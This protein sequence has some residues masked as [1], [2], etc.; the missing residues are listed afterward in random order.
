MLTA[1]THV[2]TDRASRYLAQ[3]C[4]HAKRMGRHTNGGADGPPEVRQIE[5]SG[6]DGVIG[7][8]TGRCVLHADAGTL[9]VRAEADDEAGL[10]RIRDG[11]SRRLET[12][13]RRDGLRVTWPDSEAAAATAPPRRR[14]RGRLPLVAVIAL[15][16][17]AV[18]V[19]LGLFGTALASSWWTGWAANAVLA[20]VA[21][22]VIARHRRKARA[23]DA[24]Q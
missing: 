22:H 15:G 9:T 18:A 8:G 3:L 11:I 14:R 24:G 2:R 4:R 12:I 21:G 20:L 6:T 16:A 19:H 7:F 5:W 13:G 17:L 1:E 23:D 10:R